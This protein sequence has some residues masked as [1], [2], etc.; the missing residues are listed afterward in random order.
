V[1]R[2]KTPVQSAEE[3]RRLQDSIESDSLIVVRDR[4]VIGNGLE[5]GTSRWGVS[6]RGWGLDSVSGK[7]VVEAS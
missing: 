7:L 5:V 3:A 2:R 4:A 6:S 1:V